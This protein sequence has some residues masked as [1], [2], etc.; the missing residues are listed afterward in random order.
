MTSIIALVLLMLSTF[1]GYLFV[2]TEKTKYIYAASVSVVSA[3][4]VGLCPVLMG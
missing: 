4:V 1:A 2:F 3:V